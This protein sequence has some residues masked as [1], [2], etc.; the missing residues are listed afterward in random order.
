MSQP[1][2]ETFLFNHQGATLAVTL[3]PPQAFAA[4]TE[5]PSPQAAPVS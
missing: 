4:G 5:A 1:V 3:A 2:K